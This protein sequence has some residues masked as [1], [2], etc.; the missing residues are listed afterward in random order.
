[1][2]KFNLIDAPYKFKEFW[3]KYP[4]GYTIYE[5]L[6]DWVQQV[7]DMTLNLNDL[8]V[9][10]DAFIASFEG[11]VQDEVRA[12]IADLQDTGQLNIIL[13]EVV[14]T[15]ITQARVTE[16]ATT[17]PNLKA[18]L[19]GEH[20]GLAGL[21]NELVEL[22]KVSTPD[23]LNK[24][25]E[26]VAGTIRQ[27][28]VDKTQWDFV[29]DSL[30]TPLG[31][32]GAFAT[33]SGST[34]T[35]PFSK[36]YSK[37]IAF[38]CGPDEMLSNRDQLVI[39]ASVGTDMVQL[40]ASASL[41]FSA[42]VWYD[43]SAW[44]Y[45]E[46]TGQSLIN[47]VSFTSRLDIQHKYCPGSDIHLTPWNRAGAVTPLIPVLRSVATG[48]MLINFIDYAGAN[49]GTPATGMALRVSKHYNEGILLDGTGGS[50]TLNLQDGNI[51]FFGIF[52][53]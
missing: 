38:V 25:I 15:E 13:S 36:T 23:L 40:K 21:V 35:I 31:V 24:K 27:N 4:H 19:D 46:S 48:N 18:R 32:T 3:S 16:D 22:T 29:S 1:M 53:V 39:G 49:V 34:I 7:N 50:D 33:A 41:M 51:W 20:G 42:E 26:I 6:L 45:T 10:W 47:S 44:Q 37:V 43:G 17:Y 2:A 52:Q 28:A 5:A 30:H 12:V 11:D 9:Q 8:N 14:Q